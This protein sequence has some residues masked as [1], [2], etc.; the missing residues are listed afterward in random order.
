M[1]GLKIPIGNPDPS[2][3]ITFSAN[4]FVKVYVLGDFPRIL[5]IVFIKK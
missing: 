3:R 2:S 1:P 5:K 4:A